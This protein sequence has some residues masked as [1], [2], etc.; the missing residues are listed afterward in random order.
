[1]EKGKAAMEN[2]KNMKMPPGSKG[3]ATALVK[4]AVFTGAAIYGAYLSIYNVPPGHRAVVYSRI[5]GVGSQVIEQGTHFVIP[6][7]QRPLIMDV[8]TRPRTYASLTGTKDLQMINI[9]IRVLSKPDRARLQWLYQNLGTGEL[10][11]KVLPSIVNEVTKQVV[12]QF[13][14]AELIFQ[15]DHVSR[16]IIENLKRRAD[17]F[18]IMLEDVSIIHLTFGTEYTAA[19]EAKQVA[20][21]DAE[22]ARFIVERAIQEK[23]STVI[24]ALGVSK[25]AELVGEAIKNN[26]AFVQLRRLDAAK[27]IATVISRSANKVYLN[28]D[29]LLLNI[30]H[31]T[32][33][34]SFGKKKLLRLVQ[35][36]GHQKLRAGSYYSVNRLLVFATRER[37]RVVLVLELN[38]TKN[39]VWKRRENLMQ[40]TGAVHID[41]PELVGS[42]VELAVQYSYDLRARSLKGCMLM[43]LSWDSRVILFEH[44]AEQIF[45][46]ALHEKKRLCEQ[47]KHFSC[48]LGHYHLA[49]EKRDPSTTS[50]TIAPHQRWHVVPG[51]RTTGGKTRARP[52]RARATTR[53][54]PAASSSPFSPRSR[55]GS[56]DIGSIAPVFGVAAYDDDAD[57]LDYD[58]AGRP[59]MEQMSGSCG[60]AYFSGI[61]GGGAYGALKGFARSPS[62]KFKI[63]MNSLMNGAATRGSKA[64]NALGCLAFEYVADSAE[65]EN[66][67]KFDQVTPI[68]ASAATG[69]FYKSTAGPKAIVLAGAMGAGLMTVSFKDAE[70]NSMLASYALELHALKTELQSTLARL[71]VDPISPDDD[72]APNIHSATSDAAT[73]RS[74]R[75]PTRWNRRQLTQELAA[76]SQRRREL[77]RQLQQ[78]IQRQENDGQQHDEISRHRTAWQA[79]VTELQQQRAEIMRQIEQDTAADAAINTAQTE[80][81]QETQQRQNQTMGIVR[82]TSILLRTAWS[83]SSSSAAARSR[84]GS[85]SNSDSSVMYRETRSESF[86]SSAY[87]FSSLDSTPHGQTIR[88]RYPNFGVSRATT[89]RRS[90][91]P[92]RVQSVRLNRRR[93]TRDHADYWS[94]QKSNTSSSKQVRFGEDAYST[95]V[96]ARR[97]NF[98][99]PSIDEDD[100]EEKEEE[101]ESVLSFLGGSSVTSAD[102]NNASFLRAFERFRRELNASRHTTINPDATPL[103]RKLFPAQSEKCSS[104]VNEADVSEGDLGDSAGSTTAFSELEGLVPKTYKSGAD[105]FASTFKR[106]APNWC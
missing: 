79:A 80:E 19:I 2:M 60:T 71:G 106:R 56:I 4:V 37:K 11:E 5:D 67:V 65:I 57:Y 72:T 45:V 50:N 36:S 55:R 34:S 16:L 24:R 26:P 7:I 44:S 75:R 90:H 104:N 69:V 83:S 47:D 23:K 74:R 64:G 10:D 98:D 29:S 94:D 86:S 33:Q 13:T 85:G 51:T 18:A 38:L 93:L 78:D 91:L 103:A 52:P 30:L 62:T 53:R 61:I 95:P 48:P 102:L 49:S 1:M 88:V 27:E 92:H 58:K 76:A 99:G 12:A 39:R 9:S 54:Q 59:F 81:V 28:S 82:R 43:S 25:S 101:V 32:D 97:F 70:C 96:L 15:R 35:V 42:A 84:S 21:Q 40:Q 66:I 14:A 3:P 41:L 31:D 89:A 100:D 105:S 68:L 22:R 8:R 77:E 46:K 73:R 6:W 20:Q 63:R 87:S 17:R